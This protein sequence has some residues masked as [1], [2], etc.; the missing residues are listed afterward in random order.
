LVL[1]VPFDSMS[2]VV[3]KRVLM[4]TS[5]SQSVSKV[6]DDEELLLEEIH[7]KSEFLYFSTLRPGCR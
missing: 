4:E 7:P 3:V 1:I 2:S 6:E 5:R